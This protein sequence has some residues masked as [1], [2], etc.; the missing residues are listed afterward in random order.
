LYAITRPKLKNNLFRH[1]PLRERFEPSN[2]QD[3][4]PEVERGEQNQLTV[5]D[6]FIKDAFLVFRALCK[7]T[8][9]P[10]NSERFVILPLLALCITG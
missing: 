10:L 6:L 5:N 1:L 9:K 4:L 8:M 3:F 7:L 2:P